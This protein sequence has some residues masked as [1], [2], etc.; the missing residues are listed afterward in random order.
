MPQKLTGWQSAATSARTQWP[1]TSL[2]SAVSAGR[3]SPIHVEAQVNHLADRLPGQAHRTPLGLGGEERDGNSRGFTVRSASHH[4]EGRQ[5][6][7]GDRGRAV[8]NSVPTSRESVN[9][10]SRLC[11]GPIHQAPR[12]RRGCLT[13]PQHQR[14]PHLTGRLRGGSGDR[15][16]HSQRGRSRRSDGNGCA[17]CRRVARRRHGSLC[18]RG[19]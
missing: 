3:G 12:L 9:P 17:R 10:S 1:I 14:Q 13:S 16:R 6:A 5:Q 8:V 19:C 2:P 15:G 4:G 11:G 7:R 18:W